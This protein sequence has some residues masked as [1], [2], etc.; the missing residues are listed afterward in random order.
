MAWRGQ[1]RKGRARPG[2]HRRAARPPAFKRVTE[3]IGLAGMGWVWSGLAWQ[4]SHALAILTEQWT[5]LDRT[6]L[7]GLGTAGKSPRHV[8]S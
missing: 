5:G 7:E 1:D 6:G 2:N 8:A 3:W 4:G